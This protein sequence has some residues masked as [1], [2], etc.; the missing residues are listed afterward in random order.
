MS[1]ER[2]SSRSQ[3]EEK[4]ADKHTEHSPANRKK[5]KKRSPCS[6]RSPARSQSKI[7]AGMITKLIN[8]LSFTWQA[9]GLFRRVRK[10]LQ[11]P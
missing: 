5:K 11:K 10:E 3:D 9:V 4:A 8:A 1:L 2:E 6:R 7:R